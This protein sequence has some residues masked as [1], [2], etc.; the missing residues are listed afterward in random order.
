MEIKLKFS[1]AFHPQTDRQ[2]EV[3]NKTLKKLRP[4]W[5]NLKTWDLILPIAEFASN[6]SVNKTTSL[7]PFEIVNYFKSRQPINLVLTA[8]YHSR[9]SDSAS[10]FT[11]HLRALREKNLRKDNKIM[12][13]IKVLLIR[14][15]P[16]Q[17]PL[18]TVKKLHAKRMTFAHDLFKSSRGLIQLL[19]W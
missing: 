4:H 6:S 16:E 17:F 11:F 14:L 19:M 18:G 3:V 5:K 12:L 7:T 8:H 10:A 1:T 9:V 13:I 15:R 2:T